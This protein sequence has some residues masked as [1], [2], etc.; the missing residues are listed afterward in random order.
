MSIN[1]SV[2]IGL[3]KREERVLSSCYNIEYL[4]LCPVERI[5]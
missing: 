3:Y 2:V 1:L 5:N 4:N